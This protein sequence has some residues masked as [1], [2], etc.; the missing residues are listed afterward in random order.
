VNAPD[1]G[2]EN[3]SLAAM[4]EKVRR[5]EPVDRDAMREALLE[6]AKELGIS[7]KTAGQV[8]GRARW[9]A[10]RRAARDRMR[11]RE[12]LDRMAEAG[13]VAGIYDATEGGWGNR[14]DE[15]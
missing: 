3:L 8:M 1:D 5:G 9:E 6:K 14:G 12:S 10:E 15:E 4:I 2:E 7:G 11:I 13:Q